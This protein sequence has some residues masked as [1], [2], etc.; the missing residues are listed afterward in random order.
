MNKLYWKIHLPNLLKEILNNPGTGI[1]QQPLRILQSILVQIA[2]R[3]SELND[4]ELNALMCRLALY[5][6]ADPTSKEYNPVLIDKIIKQA[7]KT[8][9]EL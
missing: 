2:T 4:L 1:L 6:I 9:K 7:N 8:K 5:E 3:A